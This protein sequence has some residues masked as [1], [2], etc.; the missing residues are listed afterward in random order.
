MDGWVGRMADGR[1]EG[2]L[3][4]IGGLGEDRMKGGR[5]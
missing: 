3:G 2:T 5:D 4:W 1:H